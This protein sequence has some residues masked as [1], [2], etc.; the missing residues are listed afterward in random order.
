MK[1]KE[2]NC[3]IKS[4]G[5]PMMRPMMRLN[6]DPNMKPHDEI[7]YNEGGERQLMG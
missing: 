2:L 7:N 5:D 3:I 1:T 6:Y 4:S